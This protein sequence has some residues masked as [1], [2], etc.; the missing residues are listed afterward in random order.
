VSE[1]R[2]DIDR[3]IQPVF[4][5]E[6]E[7]VREEIPSMPG[8][9][10]Y[11]LDTLS[12]YVRGLVEVG[13]DKVL[14]FGIPAEKDAVGSG[15]Y[16]ENGIVQRA[17][18]TLERELGSSVF[19]IAD[20]CLCEYTDHGHCGVIEGETV[21]NDATLPLLARASVSLA[22][23]GADMIAPSDMMDG[24]VGAIRSALDENGHERVP[25][26]SYAVK[27]ASAFYGPF[28]DAAESAPQFGDRRS[29]QMDPANRREAV[30][31]A[32]SDVDEGADL[33]MVKPG[34][35]YLDIVAVVRSTVNVPIVAYHVSGE[36]AM[37]RAAAANGWIN[38]DGVVE[39]SMLSFF[40]AGCDL[41]ITYFAESL[42]KRKGS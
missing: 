34:L 22:D 19:V 27:Y 7:G 33:V 10:R 37:V 17:C 26:L 11:S 38:E 14:L 23:A 12:D 35:P 29:Y 13:I 15:A 8:Q 31:E 25:I 42:A 36:Y 30:R 6:G 24:R 41:V 5:V 4:V 16:D 21:N 32:L 28:R 1:T 2:I 40:R 18:A 39:E 3:L 20:V 9:Y